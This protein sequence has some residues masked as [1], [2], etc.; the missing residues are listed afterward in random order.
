MRYRDYRGDSIELTGER[1]RHIT[2]QHPEIA[3][4]KQRIAEVLESPDYVKQSARD[5]DVFLYYRFY[6]ELFQGKYFL[7]AVKKGVRSF[8]LTCYIT[9]TVKKGATI[10][11]KK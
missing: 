4:Y 3:A 7:L 1:W 10:W 8:V 9:D 5:S 6:K 11:E 2:M